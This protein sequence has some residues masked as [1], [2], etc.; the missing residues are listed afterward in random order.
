MSGGVEREDVYAAADELG[1]TIDDKPGGNGY[2]KMRCPCGKH[3]KWLHKTPSNPN[4]Y[5]ETIAYMRRLT[6][7]ECQKKTV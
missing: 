7:Q 4:Y 2:F 3:L 5:R 1:W 6:V